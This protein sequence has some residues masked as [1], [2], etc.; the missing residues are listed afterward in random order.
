[1]KSTHSSLEFLRRISRR[2]RSAQPGGESIEAGKLSLVAEDFDLRQV[3]ED[4][5]ELLAENAQAKGL[6]LAGLIPPQTATC[7]RGDAGRIRQVLT[8]L[9]GNAIKFTESGEVVVQ[10]S[11]VC[12]DP[13]QVT[14][15]LEIKDTGI[16]IAPETQARLFQAFTQADGSTTRKYGGTGL[17]LAICKHLVELMEGEIG[18]ESKLGSGSLFWFTVK[19]KHPSAPASSNQSPPDR[20]AEIKVLVV[21]DNATNG[22]MLHYQLA[23]F[24]MHDEYASSA[25]KALRMLRAAATAGTPYRLAILDMQMP[26]MDGLELAR[27]IESN[28]IFSHT[29]KIMLTSLGLRLES[30]VM[31][32]AGISECLLKPAKKAKLLECLNRVIGEASAGP[33]TQNLSDKACDPLPP[34][35]PIHGPMR[36]LLAEDNRVNQKVVSAQLRKLGYQAD[37][38]VNG[39]EALK[40]SERI[41]YDVIFM[42]CQMPEMSGYEASRKFRER[43]LTADGDAKSRTHIVALTAN[44]MEGEREKCLAAGMDD[45]LSKPTRIDDLDAALAKI[46]GT[47][48][49]RL[50][51]AK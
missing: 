12:R 9:V 22:R 39:L 29:K 38:A 49:G 2:R 41:H 10:V 32:E 11:E 51:D 37:I 17:G 27:V 47:R 19:L 7:L 14:M 50:A 44:A 3:I 43:A 31:H 42:D 33:Q 46:R 48:I 23:S 24:T 13:T 21:D 15:R 5:L 28:P 26:D 1:M 36:I 18:I 4:T 20:L 40:A 16:G 30:P 8:N 6:E 35:N 45:Y 25:K 34:E